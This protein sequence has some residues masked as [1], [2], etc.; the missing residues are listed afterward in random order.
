MNTASDASRPMP[1]VAPKTAFRPAA[2]V[3]SDISKALNAARLAASVGL[4]LGA[5][6]RRIPGLVN[7]DLYNPAAERQIDSCDLKEFSE[8]S[9][10]YIEH[11]HMFEHLSFVDMDRALKEWHRVL[12]P[13]GLLVISCPDI[14]RVSLKYV[15]NSTINYFYNMEKDLEY[16]ILMFVGSQQN[17][18]MFHRNHFD[19]RR[20]KRILPRYGFEIEFFYP[21][22]KRPTPTLL[23][24]ARRVATADALP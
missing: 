16:N 3:R 19:R 4:H 18:G 6:D 23:T 24:V 2:R 5:G 14:F 7:C 1:F 8:G 11:H 12:R 22:P 10:D 21:Y 17:E 20:M 13:G 15:V 9:V